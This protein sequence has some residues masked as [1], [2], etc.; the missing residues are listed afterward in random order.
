MLMSY[1]PDVKSLKIYVGE[2]KEKVLDFKKLDIAVPAYK[3]I[4]SPEIFTEQVK[5]CKDSK[6]NMCVIFHY[7][8]LL[9]NHTLT[10]I[11]RR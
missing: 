9:K 3:N 4:N 5:F 6:P 7:E 10:K 8:S 11:L 1:P 2:A